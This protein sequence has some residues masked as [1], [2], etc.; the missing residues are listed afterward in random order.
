LQAQVIGRRDSS[1]APPQGT[2][3]FA[4]GPGSDHNSLIKLWQEKGINPRE[5]AAL[6]GAHSVSRSFTRQENGIPSGGKSSS[7]ENTLSNY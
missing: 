1:I 3:P 2:L 6:M 4:F 7:Y 5:L